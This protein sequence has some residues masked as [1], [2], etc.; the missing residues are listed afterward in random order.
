MPHLKHE[1]ELILLDG[2]DHF[3]HRLASLNPLIE[4]GG[5]APYRVL[6]K[7]ITIIFPIAVVEQIDIQVNALANSQAIHESLQFGGIGHLRVLSF[8]ISVLFAP[9][10]PYR[11]N[12]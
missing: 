1:S 8:S 9:M 5:R 6:C 7:Q 12:R 2:A 4:R 11:R 3:D 10:P